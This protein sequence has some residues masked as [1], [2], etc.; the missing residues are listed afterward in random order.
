MDNVKDFNKD[1]DRPYPIESELA[2]RLDSLIHEYDGE[3]SLVAV[4]GVLD[5]KKHELLNDTFD[6]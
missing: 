1:K 4:I 2:K 5:M 6:D 3:V